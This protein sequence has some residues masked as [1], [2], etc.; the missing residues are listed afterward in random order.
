[1]ENNFDLASRFIKEL[2]QQEVPVCHHPG[3]KNPA[4]ECTVP[5][6]TEWDHQGKNFPE[7]F[8]EYYCSDHAPEY[9][10]CACCGF[11]IVG[12]DDL[13]ILCGSC[14]DQIDAE[15]GFLDSDDD[16]LFYN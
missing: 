4:I 6:I 9:G 12:I 11:F 5:V 7:D 15:S 13:A 16:Y 10:Y 1:M 2:E 3:C 8:H 14:K